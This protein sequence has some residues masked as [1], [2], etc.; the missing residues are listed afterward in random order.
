MYVTIHVQTSYTTAHS[1][2]K[3]HYNLTIIISCGDTPSQRG[4][5]SYSA[6]TRV[7][8]LG[9]ILCPQ[10]DHNMKAQTITGTQ[11]LSVL[12]AAMTVQ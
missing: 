5:V 12:C 2:S 10:H 7:I 3:R 4:R 11:A 9:N 8:L 6:T 1:T